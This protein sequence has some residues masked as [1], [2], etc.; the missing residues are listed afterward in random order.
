[1]NAESHILPCRHLHLAAL[2]FGGGNYGDP[3]GRAM[4]RCRCDFWCE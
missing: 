1:V 4:R 3:G 2:N